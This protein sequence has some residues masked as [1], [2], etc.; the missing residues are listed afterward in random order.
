MYSN[1]MIIWAG[2]LQTEILLITI[3]A[4]YIDLYQ[5]IRNV[6]LFVSL[7]MV[8]DFIPKL[9]WD[10]PKFLCRPFKKLFMIQKVNQ[11]VI[12]ILSWSANVILYQ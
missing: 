3:E 2:Q 7:I 9:Q 1:Y 5:A 10:T 8:I 12:E 4:E 6:L 11:G